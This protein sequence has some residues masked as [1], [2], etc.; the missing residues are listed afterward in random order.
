M[1]VAVIFS[2]RN[3]QNHFLTVGA[4]FKSSLMKFAWEQVHMIARKYV[5]IFA[6][7]ICAIY[8]LRWNNLL[9]YL[10]INDVIKLPSE[11]K[12][13]LTEYI[14][15]IYDN[16]DEFEEWSNELGKTYSSLSQFEMMCIWF[17]LFIIRYQSRVPN[18]LKVCNKTFLVYIMLKAML[19]HANYL[20]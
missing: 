7:K 15:A 16:I 4:N 8:Y 9:F 20:V 6:Q 11:Y 5:Q 1:F 10:F 2:L 17:V 12:Q 19:L 3:G 18:M 13:L 14:A